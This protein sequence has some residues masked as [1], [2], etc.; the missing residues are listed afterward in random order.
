MTVVVA[1]VMLVLLP[2]TPQKTVFLNKHKRK[3]AEYRILKS[4]AGT[5]ETGV[6]RWDQVW[7]AFR[8][9]QTW[10]LLLYKFSTCLCNAAITSVSPL[11]IPYS[12]IL[13]SLTSFRACLSKASASHASNP[14]SCKCPSA[15]P[16]SYSY[17]SRPASPHSSRERASS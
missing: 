4:K 9:P 10:L 15:Q 1:L 11:H 13:S 14:C 3:V 12:R 6:F 5:D 17:A 2:D 16:R 7:M 8:D